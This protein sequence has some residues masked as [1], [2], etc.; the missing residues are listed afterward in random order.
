[1]WDTLAKEND[2]ATALAPGP[3]DGSFYYAST[4]RYSGLHTCNTWTAEGL[5][6]TGLPIRSFGVEFSGQVW[7]QVRRLT[8]AAAKVSGAPKA[9]G[10]APK[11]GAAPE[12]SA[13]HP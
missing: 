6:T 9:E 12:P 10:T 5:K 3:Y 1:V 13:A 2:V 4:Q 8:G 7:R 11:V